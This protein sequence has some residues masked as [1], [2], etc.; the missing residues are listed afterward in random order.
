MASEIIINEFLTFVQNKIDVLDELSIVQICAS[1]F[2]DEDVESGKSLLYTKIADGPRNVRRQGED[3]KKKNIK[4]IIKMLKEAE[5]TLLP[6]FVAKDLNRL[7]PV[8][9]DHVDVTRL[10]KDLTIMKSELHALR[11]DSVSKAE[12]NQLQTMLSDDLRKRRV[13]TYKETKSKTSGAPNGKSMKSPSPRPLPPVRSP[14]TRSK[15]PVSMYTPSYR[16]IVQVATPRCAL[17]RATSGCTSP[18]RTSQFGS[19]AGTNTAE[20][21]AHASAKPFTT[22][23]NQDSFITVTRKK[24]KQKNMR[25]T[26]Q[27]TCRI[28]V[29]EPKIFIYLSRTKKTTSEKDITDHITDRGEECVS[30]QL[31]KQNREVDFNSFKIVILASKVNTFLSKDFWPCGLVFRRYRERFNAT[32]NIK[33]L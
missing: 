27:N 17:P 15:S 14:R 11:Q 21:T 18:L 19:S 33:T 22:T 12:L 24:N 8:T 28:L 2:T 6:T 31:L 23:V 13:S 9:F 10:L 30:V 20:A 26:L 3:K 7:P 5:P 1:N 4:D 25:G 16:D 32:A 29:N